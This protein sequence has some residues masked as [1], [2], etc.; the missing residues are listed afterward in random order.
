MPGKGVQKEL[1][2]LVRFTKKKVVASSI[3]TASFLCLI[4][5]ITLFRPSLF[6]LAS[7]SQALA[8]NNI[9]ISDNSNTTGAN[10]DTTAYSYSAQALRAQGFTPG[11][12]IAVA[13]THFAW[14]NV[15]SGQP[16]NFAI[17]GQTFPLS[18]PAGS[19][20]LGFLGAASYG[21][22]GG[23]VTITYTDGSAD[24]SEVLAFDDW[25]LACD[26]AVPV[27]PTEKMVVVVPYRNHDPAVINDATQRTTCVFYNQI[28]LNPQ[29]VVQSITMPHAV[30]IHM[31][32]IFAMES[33][34]AGPT[35]TRSPVVVPTI[36]SN[37]THATSSEAGPAGT[38]L[39]WPTFDEDSDRSGVNSSEKTITPEDVGGLR[40]LWQANLPAIVDSSP[41]ELSNVTTSHGVIN[42]LFVE[43]KDG[44]LLALD[45]TDKLDAKYKNNRI[46]WQK[47][48]PAPGGSTD[49]SGNTIFT[50][51]SPAIGPTQQYIYA[52]G[53]DGKVHQYT[54]ATGVET[55]SSTWPVTVTLKPT[56]EKGSSPITIGNG[57]LYM[58]MA[59]YPGDKGDYQGH[60][61]AVNLNTGVRTVFNMVCADN[62]QLLG[63]GACADKQSAIWGRGGVEIDPL[64]KNIF[65][66]TGNGPFRADGKSFGDSIVELKPDL[67]AVIDTYTPK[68]YATMQASDQD[69]GS[70]APAFL[71]QQRNS[72]NQYLL[73]Q[74]SKDHNLRLINRENLSNTGGSNHVGG[75][76]QVLPLPASMADDVVT[77]PAVWTDAS[78]MTWV[79]IANNVGFAAYQ[80]VVSAQK[81][82]LLKLAYTNNYSGSSPFVADSIVFVQNNA[83]I[84]AMN[85]SDGKLL[86]SSSSKSAGGSVN[87]LH[88]QSPILVNGHLYAADN[89]GHFY[90]YGLG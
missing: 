29:K 37:P 51:S 64:T 66:A 33:F 38:A 60:I 80:V 68:E 57:Y 31:M 84:Y 73:V 75:E 90:A 21:P 47:A 27:Q 71:P 87:G 50:T 89:T 65:V 59:G 25:E 13:G 63:M 4:I 11:A 24:T 44:G 23:H 26:Y 48:N 3:I 78:G 76:M 85:P 32:H 12:T 53:L 9:G 34:A 17:D 15:A 30:G 54:A 45:A 7:N 67:S 8:F 36:P 6:S 88:W 74:A 77:Q 2:K 61:I 49:P 20:K 16:D 69:L 46:L 18:L 14:P 28:A 72:S 52:Y 5:L 42:V 40:Q 19:S 83:A 35:P 81:Q 41:L 58:A 1:S 79:F 86:W 82:S 55:V 62:K 10:F 22:A 43:T 39:A 56:Q 70:A